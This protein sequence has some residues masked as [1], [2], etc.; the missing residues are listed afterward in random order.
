MT[1]TIKLDGNWNSFQLANSAPPR[2]VTDSAIAPSARMDLSPSLYVYKESLLFTLLDLCVSSL[3][4]GHAN[5]LCIVPILTDDPR[6]ESDMAVHSRANPKRQG[7]REVSW[8]LSCDAGS[9]GEADKV[10]ADSRAFLFELVCSS[11]GCNSHA[12]LHD[13][14]IRYSLAG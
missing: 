5:L 10:P 11:R 6:R 8:H 1:L 13:R 14:K 9:S 3:R 12:P 4:R 7:R 2:S